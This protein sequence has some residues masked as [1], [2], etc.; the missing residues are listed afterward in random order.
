MKMQSV[1]ILLFTVE[2][3]EI[4]SDAILKRLATEPE[5]IIAIGMP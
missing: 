5:G 2:K 4:N 3:V 1:G